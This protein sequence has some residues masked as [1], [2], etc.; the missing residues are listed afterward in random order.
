MQVKI[1]NMVDTRQ[2]LCY[3]LSKGKGW[4]PMRAL[5]LVLIVLV[6]VVLGLI[7]ALLLIIASAKR[8]RSRSE[9]T[10]G[11]MSDLTA[12]ARNSSGGDGGQPSDP[13]RK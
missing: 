10:N 9:Y 8:K 12:D 11:E 6:L 3:N 1:S 2:M 13:A 4:L 5:A 7:G